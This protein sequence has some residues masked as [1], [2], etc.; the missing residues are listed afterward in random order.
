M[1]VWSYNH[2]Y[3]RQTVLKNEHIEMDR[4]SELRAFT[5]V[6]EAGSFSAA[7]REMGQSRSSV[8]RLVI[9]LEERL[10]VQL[11]HRTT[12]SVSVNSNG[13]ALYDRARQLLD[14][15]DEIEASVSSTR[16]ELV[17][18]LRISA[19]LPLGDLDFSDLIAAF[20]KAHPT[21]EIE[22]SF[23]SRFVDPVA[24]GFDALIRISEPDEETM[25][26]DHRIMMLDYL[27]CAAPAYLDARGEPGAPGDLRD[28]VTL[29]QHIPGV[30]PAWTIDGPE[31]LRKIP[32]RPSLITNNFETLLTA[33]RQG[34][35]IAIMPEYA[36]RSDLASGRLRHLMA[37]HFPPPRMLQVIYPPARHLSAKVRMFTD[38]VAGWCGAD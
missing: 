29:D 16:T 33:T 19:P 36:V 10:G 13:R 2:S 5:A 7:A 11:M 38:F 22:L 31:G 25:M 34:L 26:V 28:H 30:A 1:F 20:L 9:A 6:V 18:K 21:L 37:D 17:G 24:E 4:F 12:R 35:G 27:L 8:N 23:E 32:I 15:L 3:D 14:D